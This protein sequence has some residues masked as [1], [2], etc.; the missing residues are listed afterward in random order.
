MTSGS[1]STTSRSA[2]FIIQDLSFNYRRTSDTDFNIIAGGDLILPAGWAIG[3]GLT[4]DGKGL[5]S[6]TGTF[7]AVAGNP[8]IEIGDTGLAL[9]SADVTIVNIETPEE[10]GVSGSATFV[11]GDTLKVAG[12]EVAPFVAVGSFYVDRHKL[13]LDG[14]VYFMAYSTPGTTDVNGLAQPVWHSVIADPAQ[15][16]LDLDWSAGIY[17]ISVTD[18]SFESVFVLSGSITFDKHGDLVISAQAD[19]E[20]PKFVPL[21]GGTHLAGMDFLFAYDHETKSGFVAAWTEINLIVKK[22]EA[23]FEYAFDEG[24]HGKFSLIGTRRSASCKTRRPGSSKGRTTAPRPT[25]I[26]TTRPWT[27]ARGPTA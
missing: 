26:L 20:I 7:Q 8:G 21:I 22:Y 4:F 17:S 10:I 11:F 19:V 2:G 13:D 9:N 6:I 15:A 1:R 16:S 5:E 18:L 3:I 25:P 24:Q 27:T 23:G 14:T 12:T